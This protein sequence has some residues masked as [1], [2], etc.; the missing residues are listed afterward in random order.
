[1]SHD[2]IDFVAALRARGY[3]VT[4]QR[5]IVLDAVCELGG[6]A[7]IADIQSAVI[8]M[9]PA[10]DRSTVYRAIDVLRAAGLVVESDLGEA[11]KTYAVAGEADHHHL[12]CVSCGKILTAR[13]ELINPAFCRIRHEHGFVVQADHLVLNGLCAE[14]ANND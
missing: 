6:H 11:G 13:T 1:M 4:L 10:I 3:R 7:T 14:C 2:S 9:D 5:L 8:E 12:V